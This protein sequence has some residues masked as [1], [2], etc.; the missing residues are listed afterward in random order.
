MS[1]LILV[2]SLGFIL[3]TVAL[4]ACMHFLAVCADELVRLRTALARGLRDLEP[5][6]DA[7]V[8]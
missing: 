8:A 4:L 6:R 5:R 1:L 3:V 2:L 7:P